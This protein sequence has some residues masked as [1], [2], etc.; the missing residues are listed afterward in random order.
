M[1]NRIV[2]SG[3]TVIQVGVYIALLKQLSDVPP[4]KRGLFCFLIVA[5]HNY[6]SHGL[7]LTI[8]CESYLLISTLHLGDWRS[9]SAAP[10]HGE[11]RGFKS[12]ITHHKF[13]LGFVHF[14][15]HPPFKIFSHQTAGVIF[16]FVDFIDKN[17]IHLYL[18]I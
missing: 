10:L 13:F 5:K 7:L 11:G 8:L 12:L 18:F 3:K 1:S 14:P 4:D 17:C 9:G 15:H 16:Y 6:L 2:R